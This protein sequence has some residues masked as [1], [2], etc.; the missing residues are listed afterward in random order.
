MKKLLL[1]LVIAGAAAGGW[2]FGRQSHSHDNGAVNSTAADRRVLF[3]QSPMHPWIKADQPGNCTICGMKLTPVYEGEKAFDLEAGMVSLSSNTIQVINVQTTPVRR[4][5]L[6]RSLRFAGTIDDD[7]TRHRFIS[8][9]VDGR[10]DGLSVNYEGAEVTAGEPLAKLYSPPLLAAAREYL[11]LQQ[12]PQPGGDGKSLV[13]AAAQ[14]LRQLG[15]NDAQIAGLGGLAL[16]NIHVGVLA[17]MDGTVVKRFVYEGQYVK[18]GDQLFELADFSTMWFQFDAYEQDLPWLAVGQEVSVTTPS[19]PGHQFTGRIAFIDPNVR[20]LSRSARV[21]VEI[22]NPPVGQNGTMRRLL[23][24]R[25]YAEAKVAL[26]TQPVLAVP[27]SAVLMPDSRPLVYVDHGGG[28]YEQRVVKLGRRG[29]ANWE[30]LEGVAAGETVVTQ[31]N[32][33]IDA[34]AQLNTGSGP[35][36]DHGDH[37]A[38]TATEGAPT[39]SSARSSSPA[40]AGGPSALPAISAEQRAALDELFAATDSAGAALAADDLAAF[41]QATRPLH[42]LLPKT[43]QT[44]AGTEGWADIASHLNREGHLSEASDLKSARAAF[45]RLATPVAELALA[46]R[47]QDATASVKVLQCPMTARSFDGAPARARWIQLKG[48]IRN[49][50]YGAAMLDC[51][52]EIKPE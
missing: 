13:A 47:Q 6:R 50:Y 35:P 36:H 30:I 23:L 41:N 31:G 34:Q 14:R 38:T 27:R 8:A 44:F 29:D 45:H 22:P 25:V 43:A 26:D 51:G 48:G 33:L 24:H 28:A 16:T 12:N 20:D 2:W 5:P 18:E 32:L 11:A 9:Y 1:L 21:R 52:T 3:Y 7:D 37:G 49:P 17:P 19:V 15:L 4:Q 42:A 10:I 39:T 40:Q 46:L